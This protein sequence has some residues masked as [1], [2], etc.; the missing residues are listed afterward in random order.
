MSYQVQALNRFP[1][2]FDAG[3]MVFDEPMKLHTSFKIGG[4]ADVFCYPESFYQVAILIEYA[5]L[6]EIPY[7]IIGK[8]S[9]LLVSDHGY[10]GMVI[11]TERL[12][13]I[14]RYGTFIYAEAGVNLKELCDFALSSG[15]SGLE[16]ACGIPG[17]LGGAV[18][19]NAGAY[20]GEISQI[21]KFSLCLKPIP[22]REAFPLPS[23]TLS[24]AEHDF[25]YRNS[26][27]QRARLIHLS[28][29]F[30]LKPD[31]PSVIS[32][33]MENFNQMRLAK[34]PLDLP[35]A[36]SVFKRPL[37]HFTGKL[38]DECGLRGMQMGGAMISDKHCG[39]IVNN[40]NA[41]AAE[42]LSL[43]DFVQ[44]TV[45]DKF[46]VELETEIRLIGER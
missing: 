42:V 33:R 2:L 16:F 36:G 34:Q 45:R 19:M 46:G 7:L 12:T 1:E 29:V 5:L 18:F 32:S 11:S 39:F 23:L 40:G 35:S 44:K 25:S 38:I 10:R 41:T 9:N 8:G 37:G 26:V 6:N 20:E 31:V 3:I 22:T 30:E 14:K 15:L 28:S 4:N 43:I 13:K 24:K 17:S 21:L 27:L